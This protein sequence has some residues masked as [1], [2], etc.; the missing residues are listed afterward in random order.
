M[1][2]RLYVAAIGMIACLLTACQPV[3]APAVGSATNA[4]Q[5]A[6]AAAPP[7]SSGEPCTLTVA[8]T[9]TAYNRPSTSASV[10]ATLEPGDPVAVA[11]RTTD[12]WLGFEP[13]VAQAGNVGIFR[14]RWVPPA[15]AN[16]LAGD[17]SGLQVVVG[18]PAGVCFTMAM[19]ETPVYA[20]PDSTANVVTMLDAGDYAAVTA[21]NSDWLA[22]DLAQGQPSI[23]A[24]GWIQ[25]AYANFNGPC[26]ELPDSSA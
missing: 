14:Y 12:G 16:T 9:T 1:S 15:D 21:A 17:C 22:V 7:A 23:K 5:S 3:T 25:R 4:D 26:D 24:D 19:T 18:P 8:S 13:G 6:Q 20:Q 2:I 11:V 10:F